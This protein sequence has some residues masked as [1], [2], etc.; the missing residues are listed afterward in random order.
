MQCSFR[1]LDPQYRMFW[2]RRSVRLPTYFWNPRVGA[3][4]NRMTTPWLSMRGPFSFFVREFE[5]PTTAHFAKAL[6]SRN[7][8]SWVGAGRGEKAGQRDPDLQWDGEVCER[9]RGRERERRQY[10]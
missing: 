6:L 1:L 4:L 3:A 7:L 10:L 5:L 2:T 9:E 8:E